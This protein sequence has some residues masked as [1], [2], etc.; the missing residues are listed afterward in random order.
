MVLCSI[1]IKDFLIILKDIPAKAKSFVK[2]DLLF[3]KA[4]KC[5]KKYCARPIWTFFN[6]KIFDKLLNYSSCLL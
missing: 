4:H 6:I 5:N 1:Y 2:M 3:E